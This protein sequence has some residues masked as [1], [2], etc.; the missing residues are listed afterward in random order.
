NQDAYFVS[1]ST[2]KLSGCQRE[3]LA[4]LSPR[5]TVNATI[6]DCLTLSCPQASGSKDIR[7][8]ASASCVSG[9]VP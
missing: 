5:L 4:F 9:Y 3:Y 8:L 2:V 6:F 1:A 7:L